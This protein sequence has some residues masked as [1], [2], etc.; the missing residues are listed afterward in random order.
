MY[1]N[2]IVDL[3]GT[4]LP[5]L[6]DGLG[7]RA[8]PPRRRRGA[9]R[10]LRALPPGAAGNGGLM[11]VALSRSGAWVLRVFFVLVVVFLYAPIVILRDLLVQR[12]AAAVVS[13][14]R[15]HPALVPPVPHQR[16]PEGGAGDQRDHRG[17]LERRRRAARDPRVDRA[18]PASLHGQGA[19]LRAAPEPARDSLRGVRDLAAALLP[20]RGHP[21]VDPHGRDRAHRHQPP[22]HDPRPDAAA[23]ADRR[24][25]R[26]GCLRSRGEPP[27]DVPLDHAAAAPARQ[28]CPP[29]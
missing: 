3:F 5:G 4:G 12:L 18:R 1:G 13:A 23:P 22:L 21:A 11:D 2:Q 28:S 10:G 8:L 17:D 15:I 27:A 19:R 16:R 24:L 26:G 29:F 9:D 6:G 7:A 25:A 14:E 20:R